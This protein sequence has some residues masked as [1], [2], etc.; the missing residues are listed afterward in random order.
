V[1]QEKLDGGGY[2]GGTKRRPRDEWVVQAGTHA[3]LITMDEAETI[4]KR[5]E[6]RPNKRATRATYLLTGLLFTPE[7]NP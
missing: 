5:L 7:G 3:A 4:L 1:N 2:K 6:T